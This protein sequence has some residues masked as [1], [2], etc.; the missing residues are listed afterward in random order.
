MT[1]SIP[2]FKAFV[3]NSYAGRLITFDPGQTTGYSVWDNAELTECGQLAT[4]PVKDC[5]QLL[6][7]FIEN[8]QVC[9]S[10]HSGIG[11]YVVIEEYRVYQHKTEQHAQ[12]DMHTSRLIGCLETLLVLRGIRYEMVGA[13]LAKTFCTDEKLEAWNLWQRGQKHARDALRHAVYFYCRD[14]K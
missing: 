9:G 2:P 1:M 11:I 4:F 13:G 10:Y 6:N 3:K 8:R 14:P 12:Q 7:S 5:V